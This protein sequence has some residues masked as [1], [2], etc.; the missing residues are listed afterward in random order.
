M[1]HSLLLLAQ[2]APPRPNFFL[3]PNNM[4]I[5]MIGVFFLF[6]LLVARPAARRQE[7]ERLALLNSLDKG[8]RVLT[9]AG[10]YGTV[11]SVNPQ[12]DEV[13]IK[14]DDNTKI[15]MTRGSVVRN[16]TREEKGKEAQAG[17]EAGK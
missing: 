11:A 10:I 12:E 1:L 4:L 16:L 7:Q 8:D 3:D 14:V 5:I 13:L 9:A 15:K 17:K 2:D 6:W